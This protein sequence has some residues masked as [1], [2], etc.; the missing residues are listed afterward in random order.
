MTTVAPIDRP[1]S[2]R[3]RCVIKVFDV[4][5]MLSRCFL[6]FSAGVGA[7]D[8]GLSQI[9]SFFSYKVR[10]DKIMNLLRL[11]WLLDVGLCMAFLY[12][13]NVCRFGCMTVTGSGKVDLLNLGLSTPVGSL[14]SLQLTVLKVSPQSMCNRFF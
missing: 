4:V 6:D 10:V 11:G 13:L 7:F 12:I 3:N 2:V 1:K 9:S 8:T 5:F 14:L